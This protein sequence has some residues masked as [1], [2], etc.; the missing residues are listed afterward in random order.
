VVRS[1]HFDAGGFMVM[2]NEC[3]DY[4]QVDPRPARLPK[5]CII[6]QFAPNHNGA[7]ETQT[8]SFKSFSTTPLPAASFTLH[9]DAPGT[10][11]VQH[12]ATDR[13]KVFIVQKN[14][15]L[16]PQRATPP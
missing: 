10:Y 7:V 5:T 4:Q 9:D 1:E 15:E 8:I 16:K 11:V 6:Q 13:Q 3:S 14:G 12:K 2:R